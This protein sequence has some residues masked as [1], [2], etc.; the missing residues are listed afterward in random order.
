MPR[1]S[2]EGE[3]CTIC[4]NDPSTIRCDWCDASICDECV[5]RTMIDPEPQ[6]P[7]PMDDEF[8]CVRCNSN[9]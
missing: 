1:L 3:P 8:W 2:E 5:G 7:I 6:N 4:G 9:E